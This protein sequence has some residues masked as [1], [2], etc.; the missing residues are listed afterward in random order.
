[1]IH[2]PV[3]IPIPYSR[4]SHVL[5]GHCPAHHETPPVLIVVLVAVTFMRARGTASGLDLPGL[6]VA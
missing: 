3:S 1:M 2:R 6:P 5:N 4:A